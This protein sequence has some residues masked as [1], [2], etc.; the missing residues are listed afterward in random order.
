MKTTIKQCIFWR[1]QNNRKRFIYDLRQFGI[2]LA[3]FITDAEEKFW[4]NEN[5]P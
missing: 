5:N 3:D 1:D 2:W 4:E